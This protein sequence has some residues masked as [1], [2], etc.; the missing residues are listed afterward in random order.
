MLRNISKHTACLT[1]ALVLSTLGAGQSALSANRD[2]AWLEISA[3]NFEHNI[4]TLRERV[5]N[6]ATSLCAVMKADAYGHG[7]PLLMPSVIKTGIDAVCI[8]DNHDAKAARENGF[9][10][11]LIRIRAPAAGEMAAALPYDVQE[12]AGSLEGMRAIS[13]L[14]LAHNKPIKVHLKLNSAGMGRGGLDID[15]DEARREAIDA[16]KLPGLQVV[17]IMAHFPDED[18]TKIENGLQVFLEQARWLIQAAGLD[19]SKIT[20]HCAN[21]AATVLVPQSHLDMVRVGSLLYGQ[22]PAESPVQ[23]LKAVM[24]L[25]AQVASIHKFQKGDTVGYDRTFTLVRDSRL[26]NIPIGYSD[27]YFRAFSNRSHVLIDGRRFPLVG[28]VTMNTIMV[29]VTDAPGVQPGDEVVLLGTQ[30]DEEITMTELMAD[31]YTFY[32][33]F[34][35]TVGNGNPKYLKQE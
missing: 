19:R 32:G 33:E 35:V 31:S 8:A 10:G 2:N 12:V 18:K 7:I 11:R 15:T 23:A 29:D 26:A 21:T 22:Q 28:K 27:G 3:A 4:Q 13:Q 14:G 24:A 6:D 25:K 34:F 9:T 1:W 20:L 16:V 17:G 5:L 30:G